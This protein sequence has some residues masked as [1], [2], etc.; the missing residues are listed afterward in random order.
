M[1]Y[2]RGGHSCSS[3]VG[4]SGGSWPCDEIDYARKLWTPGKSE[5]SSRSLNNICL[6]FLLY[7]FRGMV[8]NILTE[9]QSHGTCNS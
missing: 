8:P 9:V 2:A 4:V 6:N 7:V 1:L 3:R 5:I